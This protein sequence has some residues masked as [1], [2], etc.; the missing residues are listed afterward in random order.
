MLVWTPELSS[1]IEKDEYYIGNIVSVLIM[2]CIMA[3]ISGLFLGLLEIIQRPSI[4]DEDERDHVTAI[5]P[6]VQDRHL[7]LVTLLTMNALAYETL[8]LFLDCLVPSW[9]AVLI[10]V[11]LILVFGEIVPSGIFTEPNQ[12][13]LESKWPRSCI[14][15]CAYFIQLPPH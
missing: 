12:L 15:S 1:S 8:L 4:D 6:V 2:L 3:L 14:S 10:S 13:Y 9:A 7:L 11:A 5:L